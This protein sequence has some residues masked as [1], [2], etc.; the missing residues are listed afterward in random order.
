[1]NQPFLLTDDAPPRGVKQIN[2]TAFRSYETLSLSLDLR[3][4]VMT[5]PNGA[6]KTNLLEALSFLIPGRGLRRAK[7][8]EIRRQG[9]TEAWAVSCVL[10]DGQEGLHIGT[11][12]DPN[13]P[14]RR[15]VALNGEKV[16]GQAILSEWIS[17]IWLTPQ[18]DRL[19]LEGAK[20]RRRFLDRIV[21]GFEPGHARRL[22]RYEKALSERNLMLKQGY[23]DRKWMEGVE[24][25]LIEEG[26]ALTRSRETVMGHLQAALDAEDGT[27]PRAKLGL[28]G[29][30][31]TFLASSSDS[32][33][34][35]ALRR[36][37]AEGREADRFAG[38]TTFGPH[39]S[40]LDVIYAD[41][42][43]QAALCSTGEQK[44]LLLAMI[45]ASAGLLSKRT[46]AVPLLLLDEVV[47]HLDKGRREA[48]FERILALKMQT[49]LTGTDVALFEELQGRAQFVDVGDF[50]IR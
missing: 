22:T 50:S 39:Q 18:M 37:W 33:L 4:V 34:S 15:L 47:A 27:F 48:L 14:E 28:I 20:G 24:E 38:R 23:Y 6:G 46:E 3:S 43:Q 5:G 1:M 7:L 30:F 45:M 10:H 36:T 26:V 8:A 29:A 44:A 31:E 40:D 16:K 12:Q 49:W 42:N 17:M 32:E 9:H 25:I 11:G 19:F 41:K 21:Y 2:L 13:A 35:E